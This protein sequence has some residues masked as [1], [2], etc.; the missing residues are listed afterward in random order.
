[1]GLGLAF[2]RGGVAR[3]PLQEH[4]ADEDDHRAR[5]D[6][7][8]HDKERGDFPDAFGVGPVVAVQHG[9]CGA[10]G[11]REEGQAASDG[12]EDDG[13]FG[14]H[15]VGRAVGMHHRH[16]RHGQS[17]IVDELRHD[18][19]HDAHAEHKDRAGTRAEQ[20]LEHL[21]HE[22]GNA[23]FGVGQRPGQ[24]QREGEDKNDGPGHA[25]V[26]HGAPRKQ[27]L[28][29]DAYGAQQGH[30]QD[31]HAG[32]ADLFEEDGHGKVFGEETGQH[33]EDD[34]RDEEAQKQLLDAGQRHVRFLDDQLDVERL[35]LA[36]V[37]PEQVLAQS[38]EQ[39][40][41]EEACGQGGEQVERVVHGSARQLFIGADGHERQGF[42]RDERH[43]ELRG[44][45]GADD[46][47]DGVA[48]AFFVA[49]DV[50]YAVQ[51]APADDGRGR[52]A[53][54]A[55]QDG[56]GEQQR[57][58]KPPRF[59][60]DALAADE[61]KRD[62]LRQ[63]VAFEGG[64]EH[65]DEHHHDDCGIAEAL[66]EQRRCGQDVEQHEREQAHHAGPDDVDKH[67]RVDDAE[68]HADGIHPEG[69]QRRDGI[70]L[71]EKERDAEKNY[72]MEEIVD[73]S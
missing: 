55:A 57:E 14:R 56:D 17:G 53:G 30:Q 54:Q 70:E 6:E 40:Q 63:A 61:P 37:G 42:E 46:H 10:C 3:D 15:A 34:E 73:V 2:E 35:E 16:E 39:K 7:R 18:D 33:H 41:A 31:A 9:G 1:M 44:E 65:E 68:E 38:D 48:V 66:V 23:A 24:R 19:G 67:P 4:L 52:G 58:G 29:F 51:K 25:F 5:N 21:K 27:S 50:E 22:R 20:R 71:A 26:H 36:D 28:S 43:A 59:P 12:D 32:I 72:Y 45:H 64:A 13:Q 62:I 47:H 49:T 8:E 60:H 69:G 11:G